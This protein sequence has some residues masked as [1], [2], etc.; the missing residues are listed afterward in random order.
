[1]LPCRGR[2]LRPSIGAERSSQQ[3]VATVKE[4]TAHDPG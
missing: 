4:N 3:F 1:M 2:A